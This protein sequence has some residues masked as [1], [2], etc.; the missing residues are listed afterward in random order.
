M[1]SGQRLLENF[2]QGVTSSTTIQGSTDSTPIQSL[3]LAM[4]KL[5]ISPVHIP[6]FS[7]TLI[8]SASLIFPTDIAQTGVAQTSFVLTNPF[9]A[10]INLLKVSAAAMYGNLTLGK[11]DN[12]DRSNDPIHA[13]GH[14]NVTSPALPFNV[15]MDP[16]SIIEFLLMAAQ[17]NHVDL[18]PLPA[19]LD[20]ALQHPVA[21]SPVRSIRPLCIHCSW[22]YVIDHHNNRQLQPIMC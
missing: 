18:G 20:A 3:Q 6:G 8:S 21:R 1:A 7:K 2:L 15:D 16:S 4:S 19:L 14:T 22:Q 11:I 5:M 13:D 17:N 10:S 9:T 12:V